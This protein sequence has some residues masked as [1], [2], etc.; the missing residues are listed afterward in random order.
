MTRSCVFEAGVVPALLLALPRRRR[1]GR[2]R[3]DRRGHGQP[4]KSLQASPPPGV[5]S[6]LSQGP[7][8]L[9]LNARSTPPTP[10][11]RAESRRAPE[12]SSGTVEEPRAPAGHRCCA[13]CTGTRRPSSVVPEHG[14]RPELRDVVRD[15]LGDAAGAAERLQPLPS[16]SQTSGLPRKVTTRRASSDAGRALCHPDR[17][18]SRACPRGEPSRRRP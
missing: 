16:A 12:G 10:D 1:G 11:A 9:S 5:E 13:T 18:A 6:I 4:R 15:D 14:L 7:N 8:E 17:P 2:G 3:R